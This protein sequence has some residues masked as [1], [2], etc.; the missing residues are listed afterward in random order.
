MDKAQFQELVK[1][2]LML[3]TKSRTAFLDDIEDEEVK[4]KLA[5][6]LKDDTASTDFVINTSVGNHALSLNQV[7][8]FKAGD[9]LKQFTVIKLIAKGGMGCVYL[10]YDEKLKRNVAL[11]TIRSEFINSQASQNRFKREAQIL[12]KINHPSICQIYEYIDYEDGDL[13]VLELVRGQTLLNVTLSKEQKLDIFIQIVSA[14]E[15]AHEQGVVH[16]DL[17][18]DNIMVTDSG[19]V[20][21]L[22]FGIAKSFININEKL[23]YDNKKEIPDPNINLTKAGSLMGTL[24]Y[25]SPEQADIKEV[26]KSSD[27]YSF[28]IIMQEMLTGKLPYD[29]SDTQ[30][31]LQQV[32]KAKAHHSNSLPSEYESTF[33]AMTHINPDK[34]PNANELLVELQKIKEIP[35]TL[36]RK[37]KNIFL[38][39]IGIVL[40]ILILYQWQGFDNKNKK[41]AFINKIQDKISDVSETIQ[42]IYTLPLHDL[43]QNNIK[44]E[45][46]ID[47]IEVMVNSSTY[48]TNDE[49]SF[50]LGKLYLKSNKNDEAFI[51]LNKAWN[52][53]IRTKEIAKALT[54]AYSYKYYTEIRAHQHNPSFHKTEESINLKNKYLKPAELFLE[55]SQE[56]N[57]NNIP[58][59][60]ILWHNNHTQEAIKMLDDI[61]ESKDWLFEAYSLKA[62]F[63]TKLA[64]QMSSNGQEQESFDLF[65]KAINTYKDASIRGRSYPNAYGGICTA[66]LYFIVD[67]NERTGV[68]VSN[69]YTDGVTACENVLALNPEKTLVYEYLSSI[70]YQYANSLIQKGAPAIKYLDEAL[71]WNAKSLAT[72]KFYDY[73]DSK[74]K[75]NALKAQVRFENGDNPLED[76]AQTILASE[77]SI[78]LGNVK[79]H[80]SYATI[81]FSMI[82]KIDYLAGR[83][84][85]ISDSVYQSKVFFEKGINDKY[86]T[87][88]GKKLLYINMS[89]INIIYAQNLILMGQDPKVIID[90]TIEM[91][92][93]QQE[94]VDDEPYG[95]N[96]LASAHYILGQFD[97]IEGNDASQNLN[98]ALKHSDIAIAIFQDNAQFLS[99]KASI[100]KEI[101]INK[102][103]Q[104][105]NYSPNF[106]KSLEQ[107]IFTL[108]TNEKSSDTLVKIADLYLLKSIHFNKQKDKEKAIIEGIK[109]TEKALKINENFAKAYYCQ[110]KLYKYGMKIGAF[111]TSE[112]T[113]VD[114]LF[115]QANLINPLLIAN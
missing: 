77:E 38:G 98:I 23:N 40:I 59:A 35:K 105:S 7:S 85:D 82:I 27:I 55:I 65:N 37:R 31:L 101:E 66:E 34:R 11:K 26:T 48:L 78:Q 42:K 46:S 6:I 96:I 94:L 3:E 104:N 69:N 80:N 109:Y 61:I 39:T 88:Y 111:S 54:H 92:R 53:G 29:I 86:I 70:N 75:I 32:I 73:Y 71:K 14:L 2:A 76:V 72:N 1:K 17:K 102:Y 19:S 57:T 47:D 91:I 93:K 62:F 24:I 100:L 44:L 115:Q 114:Q 106:Q 112:K 49:K 10:A 21:V 5:Y 95:H 56:V 89:E 79:K 103:R 20:K 87:I 15:A 43:T 9:K 30:D 81:L 74:A 41:T 52:N 25:M 16:R 83:G 107:F 110:A 67:S 84:E 108:K 97:V 18:P 8:D 51:H 33:K 99:V 63:F 90:E 4:D 64:Y 28:A 50:Y 113:K 68:D 12:S 58:N 45:S 22:D 13:L 36:K 60:L